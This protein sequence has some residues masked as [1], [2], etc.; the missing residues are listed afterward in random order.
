MRPVRCGGGMPDRD[1]VSKLSYL[2]RII[3]HLR[4][5]RFWHDG[6]GASFLWNLWNPL[7]YPLIVAILI[8]TIL[9][10]GISGLRD[11]PGLT[12]SKY[13][14]KHKNSRRFI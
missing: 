2:G 12:L 6:D 7:A 1:G 11:F 13:W 8:A 3:Y 10:S 14:R 4:I 5:A 9:L